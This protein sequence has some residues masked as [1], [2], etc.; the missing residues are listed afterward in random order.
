MGV[1]L[2][3]PSA[4]VLCSRASRIASDVN[5]GAADVAETALMCGY[6]KIALRAFGCTEDGVL[7]KAR[8]FGGHPFSPCLPLLAQALERFLHDKTVDAH[9]CT[10]SFTAFSGVASAAASHGISSRLISAILRSS[11]TV[12]AVWQN[13]RA[14]PACAGG[15]GDGR[16]GRRRGGGCGEGRDACCA[17]RLL[18]KTT[19]CLLPGS[20]RTLRYGLYS[21]T[22]LPPAPAPGLTVA[23]RRLGGRRYW[24]RLCAGDLRM[25]STK[26]AADLWLFSV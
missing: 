25:R 7:A 23:G 5:S 17:K 19:L 18:A 24:L 15:C 14:S 6:H 21:A 26:K 3:A 22:H 2:L 8:H 4:A 10:C 1:H 13:A 9:S 16:G 11:V 12:L 20:G